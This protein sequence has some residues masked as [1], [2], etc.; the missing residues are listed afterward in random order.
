MS[1]GCQ[2][3]ET[4]DSVFDLLFEKLG[5][6]GFTLDVCASDSNAKGKYFFHKVENGLGQI[7]YGQNV[8]CN[9]PYRNIVPW[10]EKAIAQQYRVERI[11]ML[12]PVMTSS[13][14]FQL[15]A[16]NSRWY[17][18]RK[19]IAFKPPDGVKASSPSISNAL[20]VFDAKR[21][22]NGFGGWL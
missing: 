22:T 3:W 18:F 2:E 8:W 17:L 11:F 5:V 4:P 1:K 16:E 7:W 19:R 21:G 14:W 6:A 20:F 13:K 15:A 9:P 12:L 10:V